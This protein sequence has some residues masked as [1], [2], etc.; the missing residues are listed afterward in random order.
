MIYVLAILVPPVAVLLTGRRQQAVLNLLLTLL[1]YVPG[2]LHAILLV[3]WHRAHQ[4]DQDLYAASIA[5]E[6][7]A[8]R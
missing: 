6:A 1:G 7:A 8:E 2:M 5:E 4:R 3:M